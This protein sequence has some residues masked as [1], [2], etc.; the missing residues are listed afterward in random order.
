MCVCVHVCV[1]GCRYS[2][3]TH[4]Q[5]PSVSNDPWPTAGRE[6]VACVRACLCV[7]R[8]RRV[9][10]LGARHRALKSPRGR[11][12]GEGGMDRLIGS[13]LSKRG[14]GDEERLFRAKTDNWFYSVPLSLLPNYFWRIS[15][16]IPKVGNKDRCHVFEGDFP[17]QSWKLS[18]KM[19]EVSSWVKVIAPPIS[20]FDICSCPS[21]LNSESA[22]LALKKLQ[23]NW[24][25][26]STIKFALWWKL[27]VIKGSKHFDFCVSPARRCK[28]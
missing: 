7:R 10:N 18:T 1:S 12:S 25:Y 26:K 22:I 5:F 21:Q 11:E 24:V 3:H 14:N 8:V 27:A 17:S 9:V 28:F 16:L 15:N 23:K 13:L 19:L 20:Y 4:T 6:T 2:T